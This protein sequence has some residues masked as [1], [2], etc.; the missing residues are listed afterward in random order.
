[1]TADLVLGVDV[2]SSR[3]KVVLMDAEGVV[4]G[5]AVV[6]TPFRTT[7]TGS[8]TTVAT[9]VESVR[10]GVAALGAGRDRVAGVGIAGIAES[11]AALDRSGA[12]LSPILAWHDRRGEDVAERLSSQF[13]A[14]LP[15]RIGQRLRSVSS[16]AKLG[17]LLDHGLVG[18]RRWLGVPELCLHA[19]T[20]AEATEHS[21]AARTG[22]WDVAGGGWLAEVADAAGF[23]PEVFADVAPAGTVMG[24]VTAGAASAFG[25]PAGIPATIAGHDHLAGVVG[26]GAG[27]LDLANSVGTAETV[28]ARSP[29]LPDVADA[30]ERGLAVTVFP[31]LPGLPGGDGWAVLAS[32]ARAGMALSAAAST[33][34]RSLPELDELSVGAPTLRAP[35]LGQSLER[36]R[37]PLLPDGPAGAVWH[38]L[39]GELAAQTAAAAA[40]VLG[41]VGPRRR[42]VVFG[43]GASSRP[44]LEAKARVM[45]VPVWRLAVPEAVARGAAVYGGVAAGWWPSP[46]AAPAPPLQAV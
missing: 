41:L 27:A 46:A 14:S 3:I 28:V 32:A 40:R 1:M 22:C 33:L 39:L 30:V 17:W 24:R 38:T 6:A 26:S 35:G 23:G 5:S 34:N 43:G 18:A 15:L 9:L 7:D 25:L 16:V 21:L 12:P 8:E 19:L 11:G 29:T 31:G 36:R 45:P 13:G 42:L 4:A 37:P 10:G 2:G 20:G 44:W